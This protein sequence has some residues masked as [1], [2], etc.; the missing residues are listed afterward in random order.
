MITVLRYVLAAVIGYF[1]GNISFSNLMAKAIAKK[2]IRTLG[3]GNAGATN[4]LRNFG[5]KYAVP[6]F[7][8]DALKA[9]AGALIGC[10][11]IGEGFEGYTLTLGFVK[12]QIFVGGLA[13]ILG[14]NFPVTMGFKGGK[15][16]SSSL[17]LLAVMNPILGVIFIICAA[18]ANIFIKLYSVVSMST[19]FAAALIYT[20]FDACGDIYELSVL[21]FMFILMVFMHRENLARL[22]KGEEKK[23]NIFKN[24]GGHK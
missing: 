18:T 13:A 15:G 11:I 1:L 12:P 20:L 24:S 5:L 9:A 3:S 23:V 17:G 7:L 14:H 4:I 21:W 19:M 2:D 22:F 10:L 16:V 8:G 6:V